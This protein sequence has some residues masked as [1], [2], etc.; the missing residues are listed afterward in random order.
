MQEFQLA[1]SF[2]HQSGVLSAQMGKCPI[3]GGGNFAAIDNV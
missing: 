1:A 2:V 3:A